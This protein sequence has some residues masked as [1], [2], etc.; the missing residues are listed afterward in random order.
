[1]SYLDAGRS[2][3]SS[4]EAPQGGRS[5][6]HPW[7]R[8]VAMGDSFTEGLGDPE[9]RSMGGLR[10]WADRVAEELGSSCQDFAYANLAVRGLLLREVVDQQLG[11]AVDLHPDLVSIQAGGNDL[12]HPGADPDKL[13]A[14]LEPTIQALGADGATV[15]IFVGPD[16]GRSTVLGMFR[17]K[18][19]I[20]NENVR[21]I[22]DR[23]GAVVADLWAMPELHNPLMWDEDR[24]HPSSMGHHAVAT[25]VLNTLNVAHSLKP[26]EPK[27]LPPQSWREA[28]TGDLLWAREYFVP[29]VLR[30]LKHQSGSEGFTAKR[31]A[32]APIFGNPVPPPSG[33]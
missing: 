24:L 1:M 18:I 13:A 22:A 11:P 9:P 19:A 25:M 14:V 5:A 4:G 30:G 10:G 29:W 8:F 32:P 15:V 27:I 21:S 16:S 7:R 31:P 2:L 12:I 28:R 6:Q 26:L 33:A 3:G 23:N 17:T 20:F